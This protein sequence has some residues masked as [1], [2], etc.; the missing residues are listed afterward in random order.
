MENVKSSKGFTL[1]L[2]VFI[3]I[4]AYGQSD[5]KRGVK[6]LSDSSLLVYKT[7]TYCLSFVN[8]SDTIFVGVFAD[9]VSS[10]IL[11]AH[12]L[13]LYPTNFNLSS[14]LLSIW[15]E[16]DSIDTL[17]PYS[18]NHESMYVDYT[19][20]R[21]AI[22]KMLKL[23]VKSICFKGYDEYHYLEGNSNYFRYFLNHYFD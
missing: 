23:D 8:N 20:N 5:I 6:V 13:V 7:P 4:C 2:S 11:E 22:L 9:S 17:R 12:I 14:P 1:L 21:T 10:N 16:D 3:S 18:I 15:F 19:F